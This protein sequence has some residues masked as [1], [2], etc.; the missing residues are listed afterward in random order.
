MARRFASAALA[1]SA[2]LAGGAASASASP[3]Y[4]NHA[5]WYSNGLDWGWFFIITGIVF[6][7][8]LIVTIVLS[9]KNSRR[10]GRREG[11]I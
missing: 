8:G 7:V 11:D 9:G 5:E 6:L 2:L 10:T 1:S 3:A 4:P